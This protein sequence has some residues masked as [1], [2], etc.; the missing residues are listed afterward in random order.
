M[1]LFSEL[2]SAVVG[3]A[4]SA[5]TAISEPLAGAQIRINTNI[6]PSFKLGG[7]FSQSGG[8]SPGILSDLGVKYSVDILDAGGGVVTSI[9]DPP[10][11]SP[12]VAGAWAVGLVALSLLAVHVL[13]AARRAV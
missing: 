11:F 5:A 2:D 12:I 10:A 1:S 4:S 13:Q 3:A 8:S 7:L 9:G 6:L